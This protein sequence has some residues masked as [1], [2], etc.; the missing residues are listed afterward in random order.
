ML[1]AIHCNDI[2]KIKEMLENGVDPNQEINGTIPLHC[3][4]IEN[5]LSVIALLIE[6]GANI[7]ALN[8]ERKSPLRVAV[9]LKKMNCIRLL[10]SLGANPNE[11]CICIQTCFVL[12]IPAEEFYANEDSGD[13][14]ENMQPLFHVACLTGNLSIVKI[15]VE[16]GVDVNIESVRPKRYVL[17]IYYGY[18]K[19]PLDIL[20]YLIESGI[21]INR[22]NKQG[23]PV[24]FVR[25][26]RKDVEAGQMLIRAGAIINFKYDCGETSCN[27]AAGIIRDE[28]LVLLC[29][30]G[31]DVNAVGRKG[32]TLLHH[33]INLNRLKT[34]KFILQTFQNI[35]AQTDA[36]NTAL[37]FC[38]W[39]RKAVHLLISAGI[40]VDIKD[41]AGHSQYS[42]KNE[43]LVIPL[44][45]LCFRQLRRMFDLDTLRTMIPHHC[46]KKSTNGII[47]KEY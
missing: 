13:F 26:A 45:L 43:V 35:N 21:D 7:Q 11:M 2:M 6:F 34:V 28:N 38:T 5:R 20:Q 40:D 18:Q 30:E 36:G 31:L 44:K 16:A 4:I 15:F 8:S 14:K 3:A 9:D 17:D 37:H 33:A 24:A 39:S 12:S 46:M 47:Y 1:N 27:V 19:I 41:N 25:F 23:N 42:F 29:R 32:K 10:L 22:R